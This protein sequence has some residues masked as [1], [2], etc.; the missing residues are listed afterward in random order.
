MSP[1]L[2]WADTCWGVF[3]R[4]ETVRIWIQTLALVVLAV[5]VGLVAVNG[6]PES[7]A[8]EERH[9]QRLEIEWYSACHSNDV[10]VLDFVE[11]TRQAFLVADRDMTTWSGMV[12]QIAAVRDGL[13]PCFEQFEDRFGY[14]STRSGG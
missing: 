14:T 7:E 5:S 11:A 13:G 3:L 10:L 6:L 9:A 1:F 4:V 12:D 2:A 8:A